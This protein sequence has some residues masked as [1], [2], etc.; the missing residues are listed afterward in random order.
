V[1]DGSAL[2]GVQ[3]S[4]LRACPFCQQN[5]TNMKAPSPRI[6]IKSVRQAALG[7]P[8]FEQFGH[9]C[10]LHCLVVKFAVAAAA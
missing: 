3:L 9:F 6:R 8:S 10:P 2:A 5:L 1:G 7:A 4:L